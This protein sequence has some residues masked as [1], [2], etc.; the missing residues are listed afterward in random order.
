MNKSLIEIMRYLD[1]CIDLA[2]QKELEPDNKDYS[3]YYSIIR[4]TLVEFK[5]DAQKIIDGKFRQQIKT[6]LN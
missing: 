1:T 4:S 2:Q 5:S 6:E 3:L